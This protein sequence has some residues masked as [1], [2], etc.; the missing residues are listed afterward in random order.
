M[1][2]LPRL[3]AMGV[4]GV[5]GVVATLAGGCAGGRV[6][7]C[8]RA[9]VAEAKGP[10]DAGVGAEAAAPRAS[11]AALFDALAPRIEKHHVFA[12]GRRAFWDAQKAALRR[13][14]AEATSR[15][16]AL[17]ALRHLQLALGD[18]HCNLG[19]PTDL[20]PRR[21]KLGL[22]TH[23]VRGEHGPI[24]RV[25]EV[26][27]PGL[28]KTLSVG[29]EIVAVDGVS[30]A[31]YVARHPFESNALNPEAALNETAN[32]AVNQLLPWST[33]KEGDKRT[34]RIRHEGKLTEHELTFRRPF[35]YAK[36][37]EALEIDD[38][39]DMA[40]IS[41]T[42]EKRPPYAGYRVAAIGANVCVYRPTNP[43]AGEPP[44]VRFLSFMYDINHGDDDATL[45]T[46]RSD[47]DMLK[48]N[49]TK[50]ARVILDL[51]ENHGG[52][53]PFVF[54]SWFAKGPWGHERVHVNVSSAFTEDE[55]RSFLWGNDELVAEY[56]KSLAEGKSELSY[57]FL[58]KG[59]DCDR[60]GP[61]PAE[62]VTTKPVAVLTGQECTSSC[63]AFSAIWGAFHLGPV[64]GKQPMHG[65]TTVRHASPLVGPDNRD[66]GRFTI[67]LSWEGFEGKGSLEGR[68]IALDWEAPEAFETRE[69]WVDDAI[70]RARKL[71]AEKR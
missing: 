36:K 45:R 49:L 23:A 52:M 27:D 50:D 57:S 58:C 60:K 53:N 18:R 28:E 13:E 48:V 69:T 71:L 14:L 3:A 7:P 15:E 4:A 31:D 70:Q 11:Y 32:S 8:P 62:L 2:S 16:E 30:M 10:A 25:S 40:K 29:D 61:R 63:D 42:Q 33:V 67:A 64:V 47:H 46:I 12:D 41:C 17:V 26:S 68:P 43:R 35:R 51:H 55:T 19:S 20:K 24:V 39:P 56:Q 44:I 38:S 1:K 59:K 37:S 6:E 66:M 22:E 5:V 21:L 9:P 54:L 34:L 65:F